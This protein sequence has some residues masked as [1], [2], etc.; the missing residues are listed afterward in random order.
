MSD[1]V[2]LLD[3]PGAVI[4]VGE[5]AIPKARAF[6]EFLQQVGGDVFGSFVESRRSEDGESEVIVFKVQVQRPQVLVYDIHREETLAAVFTI[7]DGS[8]PDV[9]AL[10]ADFPMAPHV[11]L[12]EVELPR[13]L[14]LYER[15][16]D[17]VRLNWTPAQ[18]LARIRHWLSSTATGTL[19]AADQPLEPLLQISS[20]RLILPS[21]LSIS[22]VHEKALL[23]DIYVLN[24]QGNEYTLAAVEK[25]ATR[26]GRVHSVAVAF[27]CEPRSHG[28]IRRTPL[29]LLDL[30]QLCEAAGL[31]LAQNLATTIQ[32]WHVN[33]P[34][35]H[36]LAAN[37][38]LILVLPKTRS[39]GSIVESV[40]T[41]AFLTGKSVEEVGTLLGVIQKHTGVAGYIIGEKKIDPESL[42]KIPVGLLEVL[43]ALS[44]ETAARMNGVEQDES[45][46]F[47]IGMGALGSQ[48]FNNLIR[49]GFGRW[50]LVDPDTLLPHNCA[51]HF[52]GEWAVGRNKAEAMAAVANAILDGPAI[53]QA[54][55]TD[56][57]KIGGHEK[58][59]AEAY[60]A[61]DLVLDFSAS[62]SVARHLALANSATRHIAAF[63]SPRGDS[64]V[65]TAEDVT[66]E[67]RL[68]WL[69]MLHYRAV[70]NEPQL[71]DQLSSADSRL[72]FG[73]ACRDVTTEIAQ[74]DTAIWAGTASKA[75]KQLA[76]CP[77]A[78]LRVY[79]NDADG[80]TKLIR[81]QVGPV[82][83]VEWNE[84]T[85]RFDGWLVEK[86]ATLRA[87]KLP[88]ETGGIL[89]GH[90]DTHHKLC[91]IVDVVP[92]P[93]DSAEWPTSYIRGCKGLL[94]TVKDVETRTLGQIGYVGEWHSHPDRCSIRP[95]DDDY[96]AY[97]WLTAHMHAESL[98][99]IMMIVGEHGNVGL[100]TR[101]PED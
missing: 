25:G 66:R 8:V 72:R 33:K 85:V 63:L 55:P 27:A 24:Q 100:V 54:I 3:A 9:L 65:I 30:Q 49:S 64:L 73:N 56:I 51:R 32:D 98:P 10:R 83:T 60:V 37:L 80:G 46:I 94:A 19:H 67:I 71:H 36:I 18:F 35:A 86:L 101:E 89:L 14:C 7:A 78:E 58:A 74:D 22:E 81:P 15:P 11:N 61:A 28:V 57:L 16:W 48:V 95:S 93:L 92:S 97:G 21:G 88:N 47:A 13:S 87:A 84:W 76:S 2:Q 79:I 20:S 17:D 40:E 5:L 77:G 99:A 26:S 34:A 59:V 12:R 43:N 70:L 45:K 62:V 50:T 75:I 52:L 38:V 42:R 41:R 53:A 68:D 23:L 91:S 39:A 44:P 69:E 6:A 4:P 96:K 29:N 90:F 31:D 82:L 1:P